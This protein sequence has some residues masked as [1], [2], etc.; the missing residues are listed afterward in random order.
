MRVERIG[1]ATL[2]LG[3]C[4]EVMPNLGKFDAVIADP[5]YGLAERLDSSES[6][7]WSKHFSEAPAWDKAT[8][9]AAI[10]LMLAATRAAC[11]I[12]G[13]NYY[14]LPKARCWLLWDKMQEHTSAHAEMAWTNLDK[15]VR[16]FRMARAVAYSVEQKQH[17]TQKPTALMRWCIAQCGD[18]R[19]VLDPFMGSGST[20]VAAVQMGIN[21]CG[22]ELHEPYFDIAC[23]RIEN[24]Q[25]Q[26]RLF[27]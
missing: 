16:T 9:G 17:P 20:G 26:E 25:R 13:G 27:A 4:L 11:V 22:V 23:E 10:P 14:D 5:P 8:V 7:E 3:D 19:F 24:A 2:Y 6:G 21:F 15:P 1:N 12:W 18:P